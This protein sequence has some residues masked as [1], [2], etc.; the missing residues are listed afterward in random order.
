MNESIALAPVETK[1][2]AAE[3]KRIRLIRVLR[4][5]VATPEIAALPETLQRLL[6][7]AEA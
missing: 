4:Q 3:E 6:K 2:T 5:A 7:E 1:P